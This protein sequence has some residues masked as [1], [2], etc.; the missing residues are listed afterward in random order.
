MF[1]K[2]SKTSLPATALRW[3]KFVANDY[4]E[5]LSENLYAWMHETLEI[6]GVAETPAGWNV[7]QN[8]VNEHVNGQNKPSFCRKRPG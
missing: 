8:G 2:V 3:S 5:E 1:R 4:F 7:C 6:I